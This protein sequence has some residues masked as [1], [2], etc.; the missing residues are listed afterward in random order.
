MMRLEFDF[1]YTESILVKIDKIMY[2]LFTLCLTTIEVMYGCAF[3]VFDVVFFKANTVLYIFIIPMSFWLIILVP[4]TTKGSHYL[5]K[6]GVNCAL[7]ARAA[8]DITITLVF[9]VLE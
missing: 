2:G 1:Y 9:S 3:V 7:Y 8:T 6:E 5:I 4:R